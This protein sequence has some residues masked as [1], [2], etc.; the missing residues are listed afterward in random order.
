MFLL[1]ITFVPFYYI[2]NLFTH[3]YYLDPEFAAALIISFLTGFGV[4]ILYQLLLPGYFS[5][6]MA[7]FVFIIVLI[8]MGILTYKIYVKGDSYKKIIKSYKSTWILGVIIDLAWIYGDYYY[9]R[10]LYHADLY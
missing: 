5:K 4:T 2:C 10:Y 3:R 8:L 7:G 1:H 6:W 9:M